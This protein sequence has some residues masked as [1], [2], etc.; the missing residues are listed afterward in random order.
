MA[1]PQSSP[2]W[3]VTA[4][5]VTG[6]AGF[7]LVT[8]AISADGTDL[9]SSTTDLRTLLDQRGRDVAVLQAQVTDLRDAVTALSAQVDSSAVRAAQ[10]DVRKL[11]PEAGLTAVR[12]AGLVVTLSDAPR[13]E[14]ASSG[15][16]PNLLIVHQQDLQAFVNALWT[17]G[18]RAVSLQGQ[19][20]ITTTGIKCVGNTVVLQGVPYSPPYRIVAVGAPATLRKALDEAPAVVLYRQYVDRY[21][22]GLDVVDADAVII[23][24][25]NGS[26]V[27]EHAAPLTP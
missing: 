21:R 16:D 22:L 19:R 20:L 13:S 12:G 4:P 23:P 24:A 11:S 7:L 18:A 25:Y 1:S 26:P 6:L 9:R 10:L 15:L 14:L 3:R 5:L 2:A 17:G 27:L 8:S